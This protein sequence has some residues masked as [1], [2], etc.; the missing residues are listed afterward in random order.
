MKQ[1]LEEKLERIIG[2]LDEDLN[3]I[4]GGLVHIEE[5]VETIRKAIKNIELKYTRE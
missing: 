3:K 1:E 5:E 4:N 2:K